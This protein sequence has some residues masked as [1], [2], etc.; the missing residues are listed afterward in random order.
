M[1]TN[2]G[3][4]LLARRRKYGTVVL[5]FHYESKSKYNE[6]LQ[7]DQILALPF[8]H[9]KLLLDVSIYALIF[10]SRITSLTSTLPFLSQCASNVVVTFVRRREGIVVSL[11][12]HAERMFG[13]DFAEILMIVSD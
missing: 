11:V 5:L 3:C 6:S 13:D 12:R 10:A 2:V 7:S 1:Q 9:P 4:S 8:G